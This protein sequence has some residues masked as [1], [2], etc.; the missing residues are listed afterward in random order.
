MT[1]AATMPRLRPV[2]DDEVVVERDH[3]DEHDGESAED[4]LGAEVALGAAGAGVRCAPTS[5]DRKRR[6]ACRQPALAHAE[7]RVGRAHQHAADGDRPHDEAPDGRPAA[8]P[9]SSSGVAPAGRTAL[10]CTGRGSR[11]R[12]G[13]SSPQASTPP[14][15]FSA[16]SRGPMM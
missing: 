6:G 16:A 8:G 12:S 13:T 2:P 15:K 9:E 14:A 5:S 10:E 11:V 7:Q 1:P 4:D 3:A